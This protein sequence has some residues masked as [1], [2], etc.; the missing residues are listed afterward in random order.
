MTDSIVA[1]ICDEKETH[2]AVHCDVTERKA[3]IASLDF[4]AGKKH[5]QN[6]IIFS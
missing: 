5:I 3:Q 2:C 1:V 4:S 6:V